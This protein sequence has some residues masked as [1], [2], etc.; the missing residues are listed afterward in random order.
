M[1][2]AAPMTRVKIF[3]NFLKTIDKEILACYTARVNKNTVRVYVLDNVAKDVT[4]G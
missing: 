3:K 1:C 4:H 2:H